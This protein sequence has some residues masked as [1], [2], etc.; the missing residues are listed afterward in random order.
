MLEEK[1]QNISYQS[2]NK[3]KNRIFDVIAVVVLIAAIAVNLGALEWKDITKDTVIDL[4]AE[5]VPLLLTSMLL[6]TD[7]YQK[8]VFY[9]K[10][11]QTFVS[12]SSSYSNLVT[13]LNGKQ[14]EKISEFCINYN[15]DALRKIQEPMLKKVAISY[16]LYDV[17][18]G[19]IPALKS[20]SKRK[21]KA[22]GYDKNIYSVILKCNKV[23]IK[24]LKV[25][26]ILGNQNVEDITDLGKN[27]NELRAA[28]TFKSTVTYILTTSLMTLIAIRDIATWGWTSL[29]LVS[30]KLVYIFVRSY[31]S[32]F[33]G[34][35]DI[36][37]SLN[38]Q[39]ARKTDIIK[40]FLSWYENKFTNLSK[41][42]N[43][44]ENS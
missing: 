42:S 37:I 7:F 5:F 38:N 21:L 23:K 25:N 24:G 31:M 18:K 40:Q 22:L 14:I 13:N 29:L 4:L 16:D 1:V 33:N 30:F 19:N 11:S 15:E 17:G 6:T 10:N 12:I 9:G 26:N 41:I 34:Y 32:Y 35:N 44:L 3:I 28:H 36:T 43:K 27:E 39:L 2:K 8:G 20:L